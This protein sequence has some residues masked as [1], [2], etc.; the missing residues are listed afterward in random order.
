MNN[1]K[2]IK[3]IYSDLNVD[4]LL[5]KNELV[6]DFIKMVCGFDE[7]VCCFVEI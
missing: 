5:V 3:I 7:V 2:L 4:V 1:C 6:D